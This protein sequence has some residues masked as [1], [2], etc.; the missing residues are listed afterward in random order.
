MIH[1]HK[2]T[3]K[4]STPIPSM[5]LKSRAEKS[6]HQERQEREFGLKQ[7]DHVLILTRVDHNN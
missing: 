5:Q 4:T 2:L 7:L 6:R 1:E 3:L